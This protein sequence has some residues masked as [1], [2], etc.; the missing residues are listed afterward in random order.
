MKQSGV[1]VG[2]E[3]QDTVDIRQ[4][5]SDMMIRDMNAEIDRDTIR[6]FRLG[7]RIIQTEYGPEWTY[8]VDANNKVVDENGFRLDN[9]GCPTHERGTFRE[10][11]HGV[12]SQDPTAG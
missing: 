5:L 11:G 6:R 10:A 8:F 7:Q 4:Q 3:A 12:H 2:S 1:K 9:D